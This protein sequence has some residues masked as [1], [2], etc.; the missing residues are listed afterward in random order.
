MAAARP[1]RGVFVVVVQMPALVLP[2][3][4]GFLSMV[5]VA[6]VAGG[7][8]GRQRSLR[9]RLWGGA[10]RRG[11]PGQAGWRGDGGGERGHLGTPVLPAG[12]GR[13][14]PNAGVK[15]GGGLGAVT[16]H[17]GINAAVWVIQSAAL[18]PLPPPPAPLPPPLLPCRLT[19]RLLP[20]SLSQRHRAQRAHRLPASFRAARPGARTRGTP[21]RHAILLLQLVLLLVSVG[22]CC[23]G[24]DYG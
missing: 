4:T 9:R 6:T 22:T 18:P 3:P 5:S 10:M 20:V 16:H 11:G 23:G 14:G 19:G 24:R 8:R 21:I 7:D 12:V 13:A 2:L 17:G 15:R 1:P